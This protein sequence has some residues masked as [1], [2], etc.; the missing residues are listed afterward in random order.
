MPIHSLTDWIDLPREATVEGHL[1][2][3]SD[4]H[5]QLDL[6]EGMLVQFNKIA[7]AS[8]A[9]TTF[10]NCGDAI[11]RGPKSLEVVKLLMEQD[12]NFD[13]VELLCGNHEIMV[14]DAYYRYGF[15][16]GPAFSH[17]DWFNWMHWGG[18]SIYREITPDGALPYQDMMRH[19]LPL[20]SSYIERVSTRKTPH[21]IN[22]D[23]LFIHAG[24]V[25]GRI[26][27]TLAMDP[28]AQVESG[29]HW[30]WMRSPFLEWQDGW[31]GE[32]QIIVHGH[33]IGAP[34]KLV[35]ADDA[36]IDVARLYHHRRFNLDMGGYEYGQLAGLEVLGGKYRIHLVRR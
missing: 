11:D 3:M 13:Q 35:N 22:G 28:Q 15:R 6:A 5:G 32:K 23:L 12:S 33:T 4:I 8:S 34:G 36:M 27:Q 2:A 14:L 9:H 19:V 7:A 10:I 29:E 25:P 26:A 18:E 21:F 17:S 20:V 1:F 16:K 31:D 24:V 30:A